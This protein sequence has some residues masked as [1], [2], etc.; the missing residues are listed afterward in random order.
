MTCDARRSMLTT[1]SPAAP[2]GRRKL[3]V[4]AA[5]SC[6][7]FARWPQ[8]ANSRPSNSVGERLVQ[9]DRL[10]QRARRRSGAA[11]AS[12]GSGAG[13]TAG[14]GCG[15]KRRRLPFRLLSRQRHLRRGC[16]REGRCPA[17]NRQSTWFHVVVHGLSASLPCPAAWRRTLARLPPVSPKRT[18]AD[19]PAQ[20]AAGKSCLRGIIGKS[21]LDREP[22]REESPA[23]WNR[24]KPLR[25]R[26]V[27]AEDAKDWPYR[28][29]GEPAGTSTVGACAGFAAAVNACA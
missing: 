17:S 19:P 2:A 23:A 7:A 21:C 29:S 27:C 6:V 18:G 10:I 16:K 9:F 26:M 25:R 5:R 3:A 8:M 15:P 20:C 12:A 11:G 4:C 14:S 24:R 28:S 13:W 22:I 1:V